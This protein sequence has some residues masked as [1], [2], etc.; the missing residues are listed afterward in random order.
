MYNYNSN[1]FNKQLEDLKRQLDSLQQN[2]MPQPVQP[3]QPISL[4]PIPQIP[5]VHGYE[6]ITKYFVPISGSVVVVDED[7]PDDTTIFYVKSVD[8]N[9]IVTI[10]AYDGYER[11]EANKDTESQ[12]VSKADFDKLVKELSGLNERISSLEI[13]APIPIAKDPALN[14]TEKEPAPK[15]GGKTA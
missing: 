13:P 9:G 1:P 7:S 8:A 11:Q 2:T 12:Y 6:G 15:K 14:L 3:I 5:T 10:K 4:Q